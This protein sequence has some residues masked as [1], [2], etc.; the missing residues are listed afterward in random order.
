MGAGKEFPLS[1]TL[2]T[3]DKATAGLK[4]VNAEIRRTTA[5]IRGLG[6][7][8]GA[9]SKNVGFPQMMSGFRGI[10]NQVKG[11]AVGVGAVVAAGTA[12][13][14]AFKG[15]VEGGAELAHTAERVGLSVDALAQL[16][17][18]AGQSGVEIGA[19]DSSLED[20]NKNLGAARAGTGRF[21]AFLE[22]VNPAFLKQIKG[23]KGTE[24]A[25]DMVAN[26]MANISDPAKR[27][28]FAA[29]AGFDPKMINL[30]MQGS[31]AID[32][33][34]KQYEK[35][36]GPQEE[37][38]KEALRVEKAFGLV[39]AAT[40]RVKASLLRGLGPAFEDLSN[41]A[42]EFLTS[43]QTEIA[44]WVKDFGE[45]LP[46]RIKM[47][48]NALTDVKN[49]VGWVIDKL[50]GAASAVKIFIGAWAAMKIA[51]TVASLF[52]IAQGVVGI[53]Q[54]VL[55]LR[56]AQ[57]A[58]GAAGGAAAGGVGA[59]AGA[60]AGGGVGLLA[61]GAAVLGAGAVGYGF[62]TFFSHL[63]GLHKGDTGYNDDQRDPAQVEAARQDALRNATG[64]LGR[65]DAAMALADERV[66]TGNF[67]L[68]AIP[69]GPS[70]AGPQKSAQAGVTVKFENAPP[71]MRASVDPGATADV[72]LKTGYQM[73]G[74]GW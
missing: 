25:F 12:A 63:M 16:R 62:G 50:G 22:K 4:S 48:V 39:H 35:V 45:K 66:R 7:Q 27:A 56:A 21:A 36:G 55:A 11:L 57:A 72:D 40:D 3:V 37:A 65:G 69:F 60:A 23:A 58:T 71:G 2:R 64:A 73:L 33:L 15:L 54:A 31:G 61:G 18:A 44:A 74:L 70:I 38:A 49:A 8:L 19:M 46:G 59:G 43:H 5:P 30:L 1:I 41:K 24:A 9:L 13:T 47:L 14:L 17:F 34:K 67:G 10:A 29:A 53:T 26:A 42:T 28:K 68:R 52:K 51:S 6:E 20:F 32:Q